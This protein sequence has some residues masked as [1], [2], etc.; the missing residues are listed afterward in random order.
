MKKSKSKRDI[1]V[2]PYPKGVIDLF[3]GDGL[4]KLIKDVVTARGDEISNPKKTKEVLL[5][6]ARAAAFE[7]LRHGP[8]IPLDDFLNIA[9][10][11]RRAK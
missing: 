11:K 7:Y 9:S 1:Q 10:G 5:T 3:W 2:K 8:E 4:K 6:W